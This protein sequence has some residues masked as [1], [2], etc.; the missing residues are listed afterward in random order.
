MKRSII[1]FL[2]ILS[3]CFS[4][5][6]ENVVEEVILTSH[7]EIQDESKTN[8]TY[9]INLDLPPFERWKEVIHD[10]NESIWAFRN[11]VLA[12]LECHL[13]L[14][15]LLPKRVVKLYNPEYAE[16]ID[17]I[18]KLTHME[19]GTVFFM[20]FALERQH[21]S[22]SIVVQ[23]DKGDIIHGYSLEHTWHKHLSNLAIHTEFV[24]KKQTIF[25]AN[26]IAG[27]LGVWTGMKPKAFAITAN[28]RHENKSIVS[29]L[30]F[31]I[32]YRALPASY[33][34]RKTLE[35]QKDYNSAIKEL[36]IAVIPHPVF[37]ILSG[38]G[39]NEG[40]VIT[41]D[42]NKYAGV[43]ILNVNA[44]KWFI[45]QDNNDRNV[46]D[47]PDDNRRKPIEQE[48][49]KIG[50]SKIDVDTLWEI[51]TKHPAHSYNTLWTAVISPKKEYFKNKVWRK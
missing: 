30:W 47:A 11:E 10:K 4:S 5:F 48:L 7:D 8:V 17:A 23:N 6:I 12:K 33:L 44:K 42:R 16:E 1:I 26:M 25:E 24:E 9:K 2:L 34:I 41:R 40:V 18:A 51:L 49:R 38:L 28:R 20:N 15:K 14:F 43:D 45:V 29:D 50:S 36:K 32:R 39:L 19:F 46:P 35:T 31:L 21:F 13:W 37:I 27:H 3:V 22:T